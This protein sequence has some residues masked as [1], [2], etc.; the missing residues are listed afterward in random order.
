MKTKKNLLYICA[1]TAMACG[2][3]SCNDFLDTMPDKRTE[4]NTPE[5]VRDILVSAYPSFTSMPMFE[6]MSDNYDD[7]GDGYTY[8]YNLVSEAYHWEDVIETDQDSPSGIWGDAYGAIAAAN[9]ALV[10]IE[11]LGNPEECM[12]YK[13]EALLCRAYGHFALANVFCMAYNEATASENLGI[14]YIT[15]PET[16]VG[17]TYDRGT[18]QEVYEKIDADIEAALPLI[19]G[20]NFDVPAYHFNE[21]AAYAFAARFNLFYG[22]DYDKV[23][24]YAT[25]AIGEDPT[26]VLRDLNGYDKFTN[27][28]EWGRGYVSQDEPANLLLTTNYSRYPRLLNQRYAITKGLM[29]TSLVW[30]LFPGNVKLPVYNTVFTSNYVTY[31][32][33]KIIEFFEVT[34]PVAQTG[35]IHIVLP[36]FTT[37]ET[38]LCRAEAHI[39]KKEYDAA[40]TDLSYWY[41]KKGIEAHTAAEI[42]EFYDEPTGN[43]DET[44]RC[45]PANRT[46]LNTGVAYDHDQTCMLYAVLHAR[47]VETIH[48]GHRWPDIKRYGITVTHNIHNST[49][50]VLEANDPRRAIQIPEEVL[51][52]PGEMTPNPR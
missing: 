26:S 33:A 2:L 31:W 45:N 43:S 9:Q 3:A 11:E 1:A 19:E 24:D 38:L 35:Q 40:A 48:E 46:P 39:L 50:I 16:T 13:G 8:S 37:D 15:A 32:V 10:A 28:E 6:Y 4:I 47:R 18:L 5:K 20:I 51:S 7:N 49:P 42:I 36:I 27:Q 14:P 25:R 21:K 29:D 30:S 17:V 34:N 41:Q 23:I 12:P 44:P 52:A 22:K